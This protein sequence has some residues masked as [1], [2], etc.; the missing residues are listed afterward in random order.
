MPAADRCVDLREKQAQVGVGRLVRDQL[1]DV[2]N[3]QVNL[4]ADRVVREVIREAVSV[5][6]PARVAIEKRE[7]RTLALLGGQSVHGSILNSICGGLRR[8]PAIASH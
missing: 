7:D 6:Q 2:L 3:Q 1:V 4:V 5:Q 8:G